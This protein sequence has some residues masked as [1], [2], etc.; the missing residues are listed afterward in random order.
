[1]GVSRRMVLRAG[2]AAGGTA[3]APHIIRAQAQPAAAKTLRAVMQGD[4]RVF[5][6]IWTTANITAYHGA[7]I[8]DTLLAIDANFQPQPQMLET[9]SLSD[10]K[11]LYTFQLRDGLGWHDG[12]PVTAADCVASIKRWCELDSGG[13]AMMR[14]VQ[15]IARKDDKTFTITMKEPFALVIDLLSKPVTRVCYMMREKDAETPPD[16]QVSANIGSGPF[17]Y[18]H[19][20]TKPGAQYVYDR[21]SKYVPRKEP[22][23]GLAGGKVA[24]LDRVIWENIADEQTAMAAL[25]AGEIDFYELPPID[26]LPQLQADQNIKIVVLNNSGNVGVARLNFLHKPFSEQKARQAMLYAISQTDIL[27]AAFGNPDYFRTVDSLFGYKT[28]MAN[29]ANTDWLKHGTDIAKAKQLLQESGYN[30]EQVVVLQPTNFHFMDVAGQL[31]TGQLRKIGANAHLA[32][33]D[34]GGVITRRAVK[35]PDDKGGWDIFTTYGS[36]YAYNNPITMDALA[37][38]GDKAWYGWPLNDQYEALRQKWAVASSEAERKELATEM[39]KIAWDFVPMVMLG[40]WDSPTA[41]RKNINGMIGVPEIIP[42]W[43]VEKA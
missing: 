17:I 4:L 10:D 12:T 22:P 29:D 37:A 5:D 41:M 42:F 20:Q 15:E 43:N 1:M 32:P 24:K 16:Q 33:S 11:K 18:N 25:Q 27:K 28:P 19:E 38:D 3:L 9:W 7:L 31:I 14:R 21:N 34:W 23:S 36:S 8:Y 2:V 39:Q 6:P 30:G 13:Q 40:Q 26:L 35:E